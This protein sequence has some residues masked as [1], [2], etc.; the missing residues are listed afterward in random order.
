M[1]RLKWQ[2]EVYP[3]GD[4]PELKGYFVIYLRLL[5]LSSYINY[6]LISRIFHVLENKASDSYVERYH[7]QCMNGGQQNVL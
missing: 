4:K 1:S 5:S 7:H 2:I 3:N 6:I